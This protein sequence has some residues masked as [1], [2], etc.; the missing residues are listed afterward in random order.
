[1]SQGVDKTRLTLCQAEERAA[2]REYCGG[3]SRREAEGLT[4]RDYGVTSW[5]ELMEGLK[6]AP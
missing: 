3:M 4:A 1:M 6:N 5:Q 2:I